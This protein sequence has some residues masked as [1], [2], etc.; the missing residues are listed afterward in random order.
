MYIHVGNRFKLVVSNALDPREYL[1][2]IHGFIPW[3]L[4]ARVR[5]YERDLAPTCGS[6]TFFMI[7][8]KLRP[9]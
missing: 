8:A 3:R 9:H 2:D 7:I 5:V 1:H 6:G 4:E